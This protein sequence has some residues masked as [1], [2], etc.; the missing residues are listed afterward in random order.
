M[1]FFELMW[2]RSELVD[3]EPKTVLNLS[4]QLF[5]SLLLLVTDLLIGDSTSKDAE[6]FVRSLPMQV[7]HLHVI[8]SLINVKKLV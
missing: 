1:V 4:G 7:L 8:K 3:K 2:L 6:P 5:S